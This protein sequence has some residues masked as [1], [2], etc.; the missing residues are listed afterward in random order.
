MGYRGLEFRN[1]GRN[2]FLRFVS[3]VCYKIK[4]VSFV[5]EGFI[6]VYVVIFVWL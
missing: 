3:E 1:F 6:Y 2:I 4:K 5:L